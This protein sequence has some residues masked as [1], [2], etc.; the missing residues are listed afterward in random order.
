MSHDLSRE[1]MAGGVR[2]TCSCGWQGPWH[3]AAIRGLT[4]RDYLAHYDAAIR[5]GVDV[6]K[7]MR[8]R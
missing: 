7:R 4:S 2:A 5:R 8:A 3:D 1:F 6:A